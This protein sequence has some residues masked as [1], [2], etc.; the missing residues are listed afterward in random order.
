MFGAKHNLTLHVEEREADR[1]NYRADNRYHA[2]FPNVE[3]KDGIFLRSVFGDG[4]TV[5]A[6]LKDYCGQLSSKCI[7]IDAMLETRRELDVP[8]LL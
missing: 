5:A 6:A 2:S 1:P 4:D 3:V 8:K 7:V